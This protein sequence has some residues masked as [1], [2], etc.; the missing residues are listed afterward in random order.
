M[1]IC[2]S[3]SLKQFQDLP[4]WPTDRDGCVSKDLNK[5][6]ETTKL[7]KS[8][9][10][11]I[12]KSPYFFLFSNNP[13]CTTPPW[14]PGYM[15][16]NN[17][18]T[19]TSNCGHT[20]PDFIISNSFQRSESY[21]PA[22]ILQRAQYLAVRIRCKNCSQYCHWVY[23]LPCAA[24][25]FF[26]VFFFFLQKQQNLKLLMIGSRGEQFNFWKFLLD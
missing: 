16:T 9:L 24:A 22:I 13:F 2:D 11:L 8:S 10:I 6:V 17:S 20:I 14:S 21:N 18:Q 7:Q 4:N 1:Q 23:I 26:F 5:Y 19:S 15:T 25:P 3:V 12:I